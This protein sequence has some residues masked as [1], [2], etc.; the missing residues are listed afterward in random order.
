MGLYCVHAPACTFLLCTYGVFFQ[1][2][3]GHL[4]QLLISGSEDNTACICDIATAQLLQRL[5]GHTGPVMGVG[6]TPDGSTVLTRSLDNTVKYWNRT[7]WRL[8]HTVPI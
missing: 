6:I 8:L 7:D 1:P 2:L 3:H 5:V 4:G